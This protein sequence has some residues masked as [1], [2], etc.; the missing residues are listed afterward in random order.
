MVLNFNMCIL[1]PVY[2]TTFLDI[3]LNFIVIGTFYN[4][5]NSGLDGHHPKKMYSGVVKVLKFLKTYGYKL[6]P[7]Q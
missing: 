3:K 2:S 4:G 7:D 1:H 6:D 5:S